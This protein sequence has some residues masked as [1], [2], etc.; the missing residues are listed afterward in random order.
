MKKIF[1]IT[2]MLVASF[3]FAGAVNAKEVD[4]SSIATITATI[5]GQDK[6]II[7]TGSG[8]YKYYYRFVKIADN[9]FNEYLKN[10]YVVDNGNDT[11]NEYST[12]ATKAAD[13][14]KK[15]KELIPTVQ[16]TSDTN[17]WTAVTGNDIPLTG[18]TYENGKHNG[19]V[20]AVMAIKDGATDVYI[21]RGIYESKSPT[22][23]GPINFTDADKNTYGTATTTTTTT[24]TT[25]TETQTQTETVTTEVNPETGISDIAVYLA[26]ASIVLGSALMFRRKRYA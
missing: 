20:L 24:T 13:Y 17:G 21:T 8:T 12:A 22:T 5:G 14:E 2:M 3:V 1:I 18:L 25:A 23:L 16:S 15:F 10:K 26:P 9:D 7:Q 19:Y 11:T 4:L 6:E